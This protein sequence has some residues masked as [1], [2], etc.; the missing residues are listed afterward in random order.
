M[1]IIYKLLVL[2]FLCN[3]A[4]AIDSND[5]IN[6]VIDKVKNVNIKT[7]DV[8]FTVIVNEKALNED[9]IERKIENSLVRQNVDESNPK[10]SEM[11]E[12]Y[13]ELFK[14][15]FNYRVYKKR[16]SFNDDYLLFS[17][18]Q[19]FDN[20]KL[21]E[22]EIEYFKT[23]LYDFNLGRKYRI[24]NPTKTIH[25][26]YEKA[27]IIDLIIDKMLIPEN[28]LLPAI[29]EH[30]KDKTKIILKTINRDVEKKNN[31]YDLL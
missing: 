6:Y 7:Y 5:Y 22:E 4:D 8:K 12:Y 30:E 1:K 21:F 31:Y 18:A 20:N 14:N 28:L 11:Y 25:Q 2:L 27:Q 29:I 23:E 3:F 17:E 16:I 26:S 13:Y 9:Q 24:F 10:Y 19:Y 15:K